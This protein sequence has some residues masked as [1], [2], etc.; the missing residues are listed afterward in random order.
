MKKTKKAEE[1]KRNQGKRAN[2]QEPENHVNLRASDKCVC[3]KAVGCEH[4]TGQVVQGR[5]DSVLAY[6]TTAADKQVNDNGDDRL[7]RECG[8]EDDGDAGEV[9]THTDA[10]RVEEAIKVL[11]PRPRDMGVH[12]Q[13]GDIDVVLI[14]Q[15]YGVV[16]VE[17]GGLDVSDSVCV[18]V[19]EFHDLFL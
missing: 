12:Y 16:L 14:S 6:A 19:C 8:R 5:G 10:V 13:R 1:K 9:R 2:V 17:V 7:G 15:Q 18:C 4:R 11:P 3:D